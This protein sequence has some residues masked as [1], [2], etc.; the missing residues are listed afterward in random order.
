MRTNVY[1]PSYVEWLTCL[2]MERDVRK[3]YGEDQSGAAPYT[4][5]KVSP[6]INSAATRQSQQGREPASSRRKGSRLEIY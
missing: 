6:A 5:P 1:L 2:E 3:M 4:L